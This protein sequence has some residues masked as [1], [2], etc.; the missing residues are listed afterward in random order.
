MIRRIYH[1]L[2]RIPIGGRMLRWIVGIARLLRHSRRVLASISTPW[3]SISDVVVRHERQ[4]S[5]L[6][7]DVEL[8]KLKS[9]YIAHIVMLQ[10]K[11]LDEIQRLRS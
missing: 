1:K 9:R 6:W 4:F 2:L 10:Q 7:H 5:G 3:G 8:Q 11:K